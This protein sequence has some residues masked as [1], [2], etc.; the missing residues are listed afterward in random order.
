MTWYAH[1]EPIGDG[2]LDERKWHLVTVTNDQSVAR[3]WSGPVTEHDSL[4]GVF[5]PQIEDVAR[6]FHVPAELLEVR[7]S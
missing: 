6:W 3:H 1:R 4:V 7:E 5:Q 2:P